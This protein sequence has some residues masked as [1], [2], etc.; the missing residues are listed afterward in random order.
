MSTITPKG[1]IRVIPNFNSF[2]VGDVVM[3]ASK[4]LPGRVTEINSGGIPT[5]VTVAFVNETSAV[6]STFS[7][8]RL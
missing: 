1:D 6:V 3:S 8:R 7:L 2:Q 4:G 5:Q